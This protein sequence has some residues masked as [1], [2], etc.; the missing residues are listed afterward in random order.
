MKVP[1]IEK[2]WCKVQ[3]LEG[4]FLCRVPCTVRREPFMIGRVETRRGF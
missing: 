3:G 1:K 4:S 2:K